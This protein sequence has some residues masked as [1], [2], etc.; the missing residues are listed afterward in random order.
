MRNQVAGVVIN[1]LKITL[2]PTNS[3]VFILKKYALHSLSLQINEGYLF[4][5]TTRCDR[6]QPYYNWSIV[7]F[8]LHSVSI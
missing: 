7:C 6:C 4:R 3:R 8:I 1:T 2:K 5:H